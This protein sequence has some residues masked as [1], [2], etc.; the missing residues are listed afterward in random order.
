MRGN[1]TIYQ[2][3]ANR[4]NTN[5]RIL[6]FSLFGSQ[7]QTCDEPHSNQRLISTLSRRIRSATRL[8]MSESDTAIINIVRRQF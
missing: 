1:T 8:N 6:E 2:V 5:L 7:P 3:K 4:L